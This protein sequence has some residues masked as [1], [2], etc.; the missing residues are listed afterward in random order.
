[1]GHCKQ[2]AHEQLPS[3]TSALL[4]RGMPAMKERLQK[5]KLSTNSIVP[6]LSACNCGQRP[7][8]AD[9]IHVSTKCYAETHLPTEYKQGSLT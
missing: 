5:D 1:M 6:L 7:V 9:V 8:N 2:P 4:A 3:Y